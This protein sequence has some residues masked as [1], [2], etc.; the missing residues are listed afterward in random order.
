[1][2]V[3]VFAQ[4]ELGPYLADAVPILA[5]FLRKN[6]RALKLSTLVCLDVLLYNY[7]AFTYDLVSI[8]RSAR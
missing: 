3:N 5:S 1:M 8:Y 7:S 4:V 2:L 6:H